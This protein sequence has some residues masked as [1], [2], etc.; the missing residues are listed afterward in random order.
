MQLEYAAPR[1]CF[2]RQGG[3]MYSSRDGRQAGVPAR[4]A[5]AAP[6]ACGVRR[7]FLGK[8]KVTRAAHEETVVRP[9]PQL[10][11]LLFAFYFFSHISASILHHSPSHYTTHLPL[12]IFHNEC[13]RRQ[14]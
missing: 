13:N 4:W 2:L 3:P 11:T 7:S 9:A 14:H 6:C 5:P 10:V 1:E 8:L 12:K